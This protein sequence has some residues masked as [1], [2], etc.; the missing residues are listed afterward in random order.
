[1]LAVMMTAHEWV[2]HWTRRAPDLPDDKLHRLLE[3]LDEAA[4]EEGR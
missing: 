4:Q 1:M 3:A 2:D